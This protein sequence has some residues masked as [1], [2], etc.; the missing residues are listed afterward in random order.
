M[1]IGGE[2]ADADWFAR[3]SQKEHSRKEQT[4]LNS[5]RKMDDF[6]L[7]LNKH[8]PLV[9]SEA[10]TISVRLTPWHRELACMAELGR[11]LKF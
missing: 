1:L 11:S 3:F 2:P 9:E 5:P 8:T 7:S 4:F 10:N 6:R